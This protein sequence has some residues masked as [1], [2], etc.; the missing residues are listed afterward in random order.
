MS[1]FWTDKRVLN[2]AGTS[3][4]LST[5]ITIAH[6]MASTWWLC[7]IR[8]VTTVAHT[9]VNAV[10]TVTLRDQDDANSTTLGT[11]TLPFTGSATDDVKFVDFIKPATTGTVSTIDGST[12]FTAVGKGPVKVLPN[13]EIALTSDGGGATGT[14]NVFFEGVD[15]GLNNL[16]PLGSELTFT[17]A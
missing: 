8:L 14:Y 16:Y 6:N 13:Q 7:R 15:E 5:V 12:V 10:I 2:G 9:T 1:S 11:F 4:D 17:A 3:G